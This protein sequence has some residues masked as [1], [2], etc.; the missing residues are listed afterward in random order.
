MRQTGAVEKQA[1]IALERDPPSELSL[2]E[3]ALVQHGLR[4]DHHVLPQ[5]QF[6][7]EPAVT[8]LALPLPLAAENKKKKNVIRYGS[9]R[10]VSS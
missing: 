9:A 1:P 5:L 3:V 7:S 2:A 8:H 6:L 4:V 10:P